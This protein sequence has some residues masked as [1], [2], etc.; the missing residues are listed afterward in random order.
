MLVSLSLV[1]LMRWSLLLDLHRR[2]FWEIAW[3]D[4]ISDGGDDDDDDDFGC[5]CDDDDDN[6]WICDYDYDDDDHRLLEEAY[7]LF[8]FVF[9]F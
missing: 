6:F 8:S 2:T 1:I 4:Q 9:G 3:N 5:V 7:L